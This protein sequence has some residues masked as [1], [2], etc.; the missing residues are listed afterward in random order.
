M[1]W[2]KNNINTILI[3]IVICSMSIGGGYFVV[4]SFTVLIPLALTYLLLIYT[5]KHIRVSVDVK[6]I[7]VV[8]ML[9]MYLVSSLW[10]VDSGTALMGVV[11][12]S[13][14]LLFML[15][16]YYSVDKEKIIEIIPAAGFVMTVISVVMMQ[17]DMFKPYV[18]VAGRLAGFYQYPNTYALLMLVCIII[19]SFD[20]KKSEKTDWISIV[21]LIT[22]C[23]GIYLSGSRIVFVLTIVYAVYFLAKNSRKTKIAVISL[24]GIIVVSVVLSTLS[25]DGVMHLFSSNLSTLWGRLLYYMDALPYILKHPFGIGYMGYAFVQGEFQTGVYTVLNI[26]NELLQLMLDIGW[27]PAIVFYGAIIKSIF[28]KKLQKRDKLVITFIAL[29]SILDFDFQFISILFILVLFLEDK[30]IKEY[31]IS[32]FSKVT[33]TIVTVGL[34]FISFKVG[35]SEFFNVTRKYDKAIEMYSGN[36]M[37]KINKLYNLD[38]DKEIEETARDILNSNTKVSEAYSSLARVEFAKGNV[39]EYIAN[40]DKALVLNPYELEEYEE[41]VDV[42]CYCIDGYDSIGD[43]GSKKRCQEKIKEIPKVLK[44]VEERTSKLGWTIKD[45]PRVRLSSE[46]MEMIEEAVNK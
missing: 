42:L 41:Y 2:I 7:A 20:L 23:V 40:K 22:A 4:S 26:H 28:S 35:V 25:N 31:S 37:A 3:V 12:F 19:L 32:G 15:V 24:S 8:L 33:A 36:T 27:I 9:G 18:L 16:L 13:P 45:N 10:A 21:F 44:S 17:F 5:D 39:E 14:V 11:K 29:H 1:S 38:D 30:E 34:L 43:D 6:F 46:Q